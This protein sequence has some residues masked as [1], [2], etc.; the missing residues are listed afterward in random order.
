MGVSTSKGWQGSSHSSDG[1]LYNQYTLYQDGLHLDSITASV[2]AAASGPT[3]A[4]QGVQQTHDDGDNRLVDCAGDGEASSY[5]LK[6]VQGDDGELT[7]EAL[8]TAAAGV[9]VVGTSSPVVATMTW[10]GDPGATRKT[11]STSLIHIPVTEH[12]EQLQL[13]FAARLLGDHASNATLAL[14]FACTESPDA[15]ERVLA[16]RKRAG[17]GTVAGKCTTFDAMRMLN[18]ECALPDSYSTTQL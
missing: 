13:S 16:E 2:S 14:A 5:T 4:S 12:N 15:L 10:I 18:P 11:A 17:V 3:A 1:Q 9:T 6:V 8:S 7:F